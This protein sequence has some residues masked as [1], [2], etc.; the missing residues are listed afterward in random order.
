MKA[1]ETERAALLRDVKL[2][3][4]ME[5]QYAKRGTLQVLSAARHATGR[6]ASGTEVQAGGPGRLPDG[7]PT[8]CSSMV[9]GA[10]S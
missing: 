2:K 6:P 1:L 5:K 7:R 9:A 8:P 10:G 4:E 3:D